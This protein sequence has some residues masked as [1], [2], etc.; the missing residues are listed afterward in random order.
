MGSR[1]EGSALLGGGLREPKPNA[2][3][4][5]LTKVSVRG[6]RFGIVKDGVHGDQKIEPLDLDALP[7]REQHPWFESLCALRRGVRRGRLGIS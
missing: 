6:E 7:A 2:R 4:R 1:R 5:D 3:V